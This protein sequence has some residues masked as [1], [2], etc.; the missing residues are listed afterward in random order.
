MVI[1][2]N[3]IINRAFYGIRQLNAPDGTPTNAVYGFIRIL[4]KLFADEAP[5]LA[6]VAF[7]RP[8]PTFRHELSTAYKATRHGMPDDLAAQ[9]PIAKQTLDIMNI[10][11]AEAAGWEADDILGTAASGATK[12]GWETV[13]VTGDRDSLQLI[14]DTA[15]VL[16]IKTKGGRTETINYTREVFREE[17]GFE[18][19]KLIDLKALMGDQSDNIPGVRGVGEKTALELVRNYGGIEELYTALASPETSADIKGAVRTRLTDGKESAFLSKTLAAI[20]CDAPLEIDEGAFSMREPDG[21]RLYELFARLGFRNLIDKMKLSPASSDENAD[22][23]QDGEDIEEAEIELPDGINTSQIA[24]NI[25]DLMRGGDTTE[26]VFDPALAAYL[27]SP[28][29]R[30]FDAETLARRYLKRGLRDGDVARLYAVLS[31]RLRE[32]GME[33]LYYDVEMPLCR[34][35]ADIEREGVLTDSEA[36]REFGEMLAIRVDKAEGRIYELAGEVFNI[37]SPKQLGEVLFEKLMLPS[38]KKTKTGY[39]TAAEELDRLE[40]KHPVISAVKEYR[41]LTKLK[42]TYADGLLRVIAPD[43]RIHTSFQMTTTA[44]GR[45]SSTEPNLQNIPVRRELGAELRRM[46]I[47]PPGRL[48]IDADYSQIELR[49]LAHIA[50]D[51]AML[52]AFRAGEDIHAVTAARVF[53]TALSEVTPLLRGRAKAVNFGIVYGIS[54][55]SLSKDIGVSVA[56]AKEYIDGYLERF[57]GVRAY[58]TDIVERAKRD[59]YVTTLFGRRR[60]VPELA[61]RD[62]N[63]RAFGE[64]VALNTPIQGTAADIIKIA[65]VR[66]YERLKAES[67]ESK[68]IL[69]VH[70]ELIAEAPESEASG[71][72]EML[73]R[74]MEGA[75]S[76]DVPLTVQTGIGQSWADCK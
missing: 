35:L 22:E 76:L 49:L 1:D 2:G 60:Y 67:R 42:A 58:M 7:D 39:S 3:S 24:F 16:L 59:G 28:T 41:E 12:R 66:T 34:V 50:G 61:S 21:A 65:M 44:T 18:P 20:R 30:Q 69:Q 27:I 40:D 74:E 43:G 62:H 71:V 52:D 37:A 33:R 72:A 53:G 45:L 32:D 6:L 9:M 47:S 11:R 25:K 36:L 73:R 57:S 19:I 26:Y 23:A 68:L 17:Y 13:I 14:S 75:A 56:E 10:A 46:F 54:A 63:M 38:P 4:Q 55:F 8:E 15:R 70:D 29:D 64:R 31:E 51:S 5:E 48:L